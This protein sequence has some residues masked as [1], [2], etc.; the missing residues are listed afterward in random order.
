[1]LEN[2]LLE[3]R[4]PARTTAATRKNGARSSLSSQPIDLSIS[5]IRAY[6]FECRPRQPT[7]QPQFAREEQRRPASLIVSR[8]PCYILLEG[9]KELYS[10]EIHIDTHTYTRTYTY[11]HSAHATRGVSVSC[12][13]SRLALLLFFPLPFFPAEQ[14]SVVFLPR[15][16]PSE[17]I[18][19]RE[20]SRYTSI[21]C[22][23]GANARGRSAISSY[24]VG[25]YSLEKKRKRENHEEI[26]VRSDRSPF[27]PFEDFL[28][29]RTVMQITTE[30]VTRI[31]YTYIYTHTH[32]GI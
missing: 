7:R 8:P 9:V 6:T 25:P 30:L 16:L 1:M 12:V 3:G 5:F 31:T 10:T 15:T 2:C 13:L 4:K 19:S 11:T 23:K 17:M 14:P 32:A 21:G 29:P 27:S 26:G 22:E 20:V 24:L 18:W 28:E